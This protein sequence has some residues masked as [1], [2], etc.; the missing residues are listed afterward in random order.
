MPIGMKHRVQD[1]SLQVTKISYLCF[2]GIITRDVPV[3]EN[4]AERLRNLILITGLLRHHHITFRQA[5]PKRITF[6]SY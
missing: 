1:D 5:T 4:Q 2:F 6:P 3:I